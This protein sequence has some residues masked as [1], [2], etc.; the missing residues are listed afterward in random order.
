MV[1][2]RYQQT[3]AY[4]W[5]TAYFFFLGPG[6]NGYISDDHINTYII[7]LILPLGLQSLKFTI[8]ALRGNLAIP[9]LALPPSPWYPTNEKAQRGEIVCSKALAG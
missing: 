5:P 8:W 7:A 2:H 9:D 1:Y 3:M 4:G 6:A